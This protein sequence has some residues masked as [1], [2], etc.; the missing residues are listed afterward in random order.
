MGIPEP[1]RV[2]L[3][4]DDHQIAVEN[5][6]RLQALEYTVVGKAHN[7]QEAVEMVAEL[8]PDV[9]LMDIRM[10]VMDG[11]EA[12]RLIQSTCPTPVVIL[13]SHETPEMLEEASQAGAGAYL[14]KP[15]VQ[16]EI[17]RAITIAMARHG[18]IIKWRQLSEELQ[19][20]NQEL[21][22]ALDDV[23]LLGGLL[24]ICSNCKDIRDD[25][26]YWNRIEMFIEEHTGADFTHG[27]CPK[28][29]RELYPDIIY[30]KD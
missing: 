22:A 12:T 26:G 20:K 7:G 23:K 24:P 15:P 18:D 4:D 17:Q 2:V 6:R 5:E 21:K 19:S 8:K 13:T 27:M 25:K 1:L 10:P 30:P 16:K 14:M 28:C 9:V 3:A 29:A 11:L